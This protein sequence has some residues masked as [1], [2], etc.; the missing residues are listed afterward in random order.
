MI[1][2]YIVVAII[3]LYVIIFIRVN[4]RLQKLKS[5]YGLS[6][7][8]MEEI[9]KYHKASNVDKWIIQRYLSEK[10]KQRFRDKHVMSD[11]DYE[12]L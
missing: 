12:N 8:D 4:N 5:M 7:T 11:S 9:L 10:S 2:V 3:I 1:V 6:Q